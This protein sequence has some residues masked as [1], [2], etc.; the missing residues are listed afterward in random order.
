MIRKYLTQQQY[1]D[2]DGK[3][4][5]NVDY[6]IVENGSP[7]NVTFV[8][9]NITGLDEMYDF[10]PTP[11]GTYNITENGEYDVAAYASA[12]VDVPSGC[13]ALEARYN[14]LFNNNITYLDNTYIPIGSRSVGY[15]LCFGNSYLLSIDLSSVTNID[16]YAF[17]YCSN[18]TSVNLPD[19]TQVGAYCFQYC[20]S[21]TYIDLPST[22]YIGKSAFFR[23]RNIVTAYLPSLNHIDSGEVFSNCDKLTSIDI[24]SLPDTSS[25]TFMG[26]HS[27]TTVNNT[28]VLAYVGLNAFDGCTNLTTID[29][30]GITHIWGSGFNKCSS[31]TTVNL[32]SIVDIGSSGY[33]A[34][35]ECRS[36]TTV[37]LGPNIK[38]I[39]NR[40]FYNCSS[41]TSFTCRATTPPSLGAAAFNGTPANLVIYVPAESVDAYKAAKNWSTY[42]DKIQTIVE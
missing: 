7:I 19:V 4:N 6:V 41:L 10:A 1:D 30:S 32:P 38:Y 23:D 42:A 25:K 14:S 18:L 20:T 9:N 16:D 22:T 29:M 13:E 34:F 2:L 5:S 27:L 40:S 26:C 31:L 28:S 35:R 17:Y 37:D 33:D 15:G 8:T 36:L 24:Q 21:L 11:E 12:Y 3:L 39:Y